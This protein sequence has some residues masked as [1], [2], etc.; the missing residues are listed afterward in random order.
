MLQLGIAG[1]ELILGMIVGFAGGRWGGRWLT[2]IVA[3]GVLANIGVDLR[4]SET[5]ACP[6]GADCDP[7][8]W[9]N[10]AWLGIALV[11]GWL[12]AVAMGFALSIR[13]ERTS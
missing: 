1:G 9:A 5:Y 6:A 4:A 3:L 12:L 7:V 10:W 13:F 11:G 8:T 2:V